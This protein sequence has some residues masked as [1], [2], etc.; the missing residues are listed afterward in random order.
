MRKLLVVEDHPLMRLLVERDLTR[1]GF[2]ADFAASGQEAIELVA[3]HA[4][5]LIFMDVMMPEIDGLETTRRIRAFERACGRDPCMIVAM[6]ASHDRQGCFD[7]GMDD[8]LAKPVSIEQLKETIV[9]N[10]AE[11]GAQENRQPTAPL[12]GGG[13][14]IGAQPNDI[15][16]NGTQI[17][18]AQVTGSQ[19]TDTQISGAQ[20]AGPQEITHRNGTPLFLI[21]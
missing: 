3:G 20:S 15:Q 18:G 2:E 8:F 9:K 13:E 14:I 19:I 4:Y 16:I 10:V 5:R 11:S 12:P 1:L 21:P 17:S 7:A 6:T